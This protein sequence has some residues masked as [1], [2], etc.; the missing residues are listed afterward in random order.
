MKDRIFTTNPTFIEDL[1]VTITTVIQSIDV[2][3]LRKVFQ[4]MMKRVK[5][6]L[7]VDSE[8]DEASESMSKC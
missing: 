1:K 3:T 6:C 2:R 4:N 8:Y 7:S 5:A